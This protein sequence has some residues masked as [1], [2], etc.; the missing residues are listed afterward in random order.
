MKTHI[1]ADE[2]CE[3]E[4]MAVVL[5]DQTF[6]SPNLVAQAVRDNIIFR[7]MFLDG[8]VLILYLLMCLLVILAFCSV[9]CGDDD[10]DDVVVGM[11][12]LVGGPS[13]CHRASQ[14]LYMSSNTLDISY[15]ELCLSSFHLLYRISLCMWDLVK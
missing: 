8:A 9:V 3:Q 4:I 5:R 13:C 14:L 15:P 12:T 11:L 6:V 2:F 7:K 10:D 1:L